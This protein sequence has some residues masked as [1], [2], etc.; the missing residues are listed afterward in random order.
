MSFRPFSEIEGAF[1]LGL[2][3]VIVLLLYLYAFEFFRYRTVRNKFKRK[4]NVILPLWMSFFG[5]YI[6]IRSSLVVGLIILGLGFLTYMW[7]KAMM[8]SIT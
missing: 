2:F 6:L 1:V 3:A 4:Y 5:F 8:N 7:D